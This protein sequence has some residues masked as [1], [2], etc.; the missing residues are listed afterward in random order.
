MP[1]LLKDLKIT[2]VSSVDRGAGRGVKV[3]LMKR[4]D[5]SE[6]ERVAAFVNGLID[7]AVAEGVA[8]LDAE[9]AALRGKKQTTG[10]DSLILEKR[11]A[12]QADTHRKADTPMTD[13]IGKAFREVSDFDLVA[14]V[15]QAVAKGEVTKAALDEQLWRRA[16]AKKRDGEDRGRA[17][18]RLFV[19][20]AD[21]TGRELYRT[22]KAMPGRDYHQTLA[23][24]AAAEAP[25]IGKRDPG[26]VD[27]VAKVQV[28]AD[29]IRKL[30]PEITAAAATL[31]AYGTP[32]ARRLTAESMSK[33]LGI[34]VAKIDDAAETSPG[35]QALEKSARDLQAAD[36]EL[37]DVKAFVAACETPAGRQL[38][39]ADR[40]WSA[41]RMEALAAA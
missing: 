4:D 3:V 36:P 35:Y 23:A 16:D 6:E 28:I 41:A 9:I 33:R 22:M 19:D 27:V 34:P 38:L 31:R 29:Q 2:E 14:T 32:E 30:H 12:R 20:G 26:D 39:K 5:D 37:S 18:V 13:D 21:E 17:F 8:K 10:T 7:A 15:D 11:P 1:R 25:P 24:K 40:E